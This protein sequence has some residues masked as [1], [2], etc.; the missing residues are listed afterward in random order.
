MSTV[1]GGELFAKALKKE[2]VTQIFTLC[3]S[4][5]MPI[6]YGCRKAGIKVIDFRHEA[7]AAYAADAYARVSG[8]PGIVVT[9]AGPACLNTTAAMAE[10]KQHGVPVIHIS[11]AAR[12]LENDTGTLQDINTLEVMSSVTKWARNIYH[13]QRIPE[14]VAMAFRQ[15]LANTPGP[16]F[17]GIATDVLLEE[18]TENT[19]YYPE[20]YRTEAKAFGDPAL[21]EQAAGLLA[22]A[23]KPLLIIGDTAR[24]NTMY[25]E[26]VEELVNYLKIP[27]FTVTQTRGLFGD[28]DNPLFSSGRAAAGTADVIVMLEVDPNY[29]VGKC[30]MIK[31]DAKVIQVAPDITRIGYNVKADIGIVG[32]SGPVIKQLLE[33]VKTKISQQN[34]TT[35]AD[36]AATLTKKASEVFTQAFTSDKHPINPGRCA[37]EVA[38]FIDT[39]ARDWNIV[40][41]G[42]EANLWLAAAVKV[43]RPGQLLD[44]G[45]LGGIGPGPGLTLGAWAASGKPVLYYTG[46]GS[47]GFYAMELDTM[48]RQGV[49]VVCVISND[50]AW[51]MIKHGES[52][53]S[54]LET[55]NGYVGVELAKN[56][57]Y[58][59][60][61]AMWGGIGIMVTEP[62]DIIPAIQEVYQSGLPGIVN[63]AVDPDIIN[64]IT[65]SIGCFTVD[66]KNT[67]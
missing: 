9:T 39:E 30:R 32:G 67:K 52:F 4:Q 24:F 51:G 27:V 20:Q 21:V 13:G 60:M 61:A 47:F 44:L 16:V 10:A 1:N 36:V 45:T 37:A 8:K 53:R 17:L 49:P 23:K 6:Y 56:R 54:P 29:L 28:E 41:D 33:A 3:G 62:E 2:G 15:C 55:A 18:F 63:V 35:W 66:N 65:M 46:D 50:S 64:P 38:K 14:Y 40:I 42:G 48:A 31:E 34:D 19:I 26:A 43:H 5:I 59:K 7:A 11:G 57:H 22:A 25:G 58:E 12:L